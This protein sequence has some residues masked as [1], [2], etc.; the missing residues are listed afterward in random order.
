LFTFEAMLTDQ[1]KMLATN[2][3]SEMTSI[4]HLQNCGSGNT[5]GKVNKDFLASIEICQHSYFLQSKLIELMD[6]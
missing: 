3:L 4:G 2:K 1:K 6:V 5:T